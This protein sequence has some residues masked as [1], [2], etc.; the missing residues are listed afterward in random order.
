MEEL[1]SLEILNSLKDKAIDISKKVTERKNNVHKYVNFSYWKAYVSI[2][3][4]ELYD[5]LC[6]PIQES[7][8]LLYCTI[9][10]KKLTNKEVSFIM[11]NWDFFNVILCNRPFQKTE[12]CLYYDNPFNEQIILISENVNYIPWSY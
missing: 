10:F 11:D 5:Y 9:Q 3:F 2:E 1:S 7:G 4:G 6:L 8:S 12:K